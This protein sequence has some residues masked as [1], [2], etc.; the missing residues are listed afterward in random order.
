MAG[1]G[2]ESLIPKKIQRN[3]VPTVKDEAIYYIE[4]EKINSNPY[5]PRKHFDQ[6]ALASLSQSIQDYGILQ[7]LVVSKIEKQT[8]T[9]QQIEYQLIA[10]ERRLLAS[11]IAGLTQVPVI[12]R[13]TTSKQKL[14][15]SLIEN[16]QRLD[17]DPIDKALAFKK[18]QEEFNFSRK[19]VAR[20][21]GKSKESVANTL[22]LLNLPEEIK[23]ELKLGKITEGHARA[24]LSVQ[25]ERKQKILCS[26]IIKD[27]L[28]VRET[29]ILIQKLN[30]CKPSS[31]PAILPVVDK[32]VQEFQEQLKKISGVARLKLKIELGRPKLDI[33]FNSKKEFKSFLNKVLKK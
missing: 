2:L 10:G 4:I 20:L 12:I 24:I 29:D 9:G 27:G 22:R 17:L 18:L 15:L 31:K 5:Q 23:Q 7:P 11:K 6:K 19:D 32:D 25:D 3:I 30:I 33:M 1:K 14:E 8:P 28:N 21:C 16:V 26:R 13:Q